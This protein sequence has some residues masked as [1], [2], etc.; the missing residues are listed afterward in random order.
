[1]SQ[2]RKSTINQTISDFIPA[3]YFI[4]RAIPGTPFFFASDKK[5]EQIAPLLPRSQFYAQPFRTAAPG[6]QICDR[7]LC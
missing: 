5:F 2:L 1:M 3:C 7:S 4:R 6:Q